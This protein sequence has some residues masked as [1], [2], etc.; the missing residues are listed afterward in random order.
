M[1]SESEI[2]KHYKSCGK[3]LETWWKYKKY[4]SRYQIT[5]ILRRN[6]VLNRKGGAHNV[7]DELIVDNSRAFRYLTDKELDFENEIKTKLF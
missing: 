1:T 2:I 6:G 4:F 5:D 7:A 3:V